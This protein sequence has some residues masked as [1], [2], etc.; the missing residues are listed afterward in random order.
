LVRG[1]KK[2]DVGY[3]HRDID[4]WNLG[5][6]RKGSIKPLYIWKIWIPIWGCNKKNTLRLIPG[7]NKQ[8]IKI[9]YLK[10]NGRVKPKIS[11][12]YFKTY[13][14][15]SL[16]GLKYKN[17]FNAILFHAKTVHFAPINLS[18]KLR[19]SAEFTTFA[20]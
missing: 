16:P 6:R 2:K 15:F 8:K 9:S 17:N 12:K 13:K 18:T 5:I 11:S 4:F 20:N 3:P 10:K 1:D 7:S 14:K 19:I